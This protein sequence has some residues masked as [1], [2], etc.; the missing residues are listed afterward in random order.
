[1]PITLGSNTIS[2]LTA[3]GLPAGS[4]TNSNIASSTIAGDR[5]ATNAKIYYT[6]AARNSNQQ[7]GGD[8]GWNDY[9]SVSF[10][11]TY[12]G[13]FMVFTT[14]GNSWESGPVQGF[15]RFLLNGSKIGVNFLVARQT[16]NNSA[17]S[18]QGLWSGSVGAGTHTIM[19]QTRNLSGTWQTN[20]WGYDETSVT[21]LAVGYYP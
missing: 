20:Y 16:N 5:L 19:L 17:A 12:G 6:V 9:L 10:T 14:W 13:H 8:S 11:S 4:V 7:L 2:G 1:M 3:G 15:C 18:G 21:T